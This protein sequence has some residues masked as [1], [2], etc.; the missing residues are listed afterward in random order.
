MDK[1]NRTVKVHLNNNWLEL[2][3][4]W[5]EAIKEA[6]KMKLEM[7]YKE[8]GTI[9]SGSPVEK[10]NRNYIIYDDIDFSSKYF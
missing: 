5:E 3:R 1:A 7:I 10:L 9:I 8:K 4:K 6:N 2:V